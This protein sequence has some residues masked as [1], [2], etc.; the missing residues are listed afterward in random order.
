VVGREVLQLIWD[1]QAEMLQLIGEELITMSL[2]RGLSSR[3]AQGTPLLADLSS[4]GGISK[5]V[6]PANTRPSDRQAELP[7]PGSIRARGTAFAEKG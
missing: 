5:K 6:T 4:A 3:G 1:P 7:A 2:P